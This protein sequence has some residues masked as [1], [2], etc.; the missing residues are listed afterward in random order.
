[1]P[2]VRVPTAILDLRRQL[3][4]LPERRKAAERL[5]TI[6]TFGQMALGAAA[7][8]QRAL[9]AIICTDQ[10]FDAANLKDARAAVG[11]NVKTATRLLKE[12]TGIEAVDKGV[13]ESM[14]QDLQAGAA[15]A[16]STVEQEWTRQ[17]SAVTARFQRIVTVAE[18]AGLPKSERLSDTLRKIQASTRPRC[19]DGSSVADYLLEL[20]KT[21]RTLGLEGEGGAFLSRVADGSARAQDLTRPEIV[22]FLTDYELWPLLTVRFSQ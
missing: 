20:H 11:R 22:E 5:A 8:Q 1:M 4:S 19:N 6:R 18:R 17:I 9:E 13:I 2:D 21:V 16:V 15:K 7:Q 12:L 3:E 14:F 10:T